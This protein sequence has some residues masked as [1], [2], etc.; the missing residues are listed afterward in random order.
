MK[1][2]LDWIGKAALVGAVAVIGFQVLRN[3]A[4]GGGSTSRPTE[5]TMV[6]VRVL[7][8]EGTL[9]EPVTMPAI[10][11]TEADWKELLTP[12]QFRIVRSAGTERPFCGGLLKNHEDGMY[13]CVACGL[14]LFKSDSKFESGTGWPSFFQPVAKENIEEKRDVSYGMVRVETNCQRC[15]AHLGH[16]FEDGPRP[17]GLRYCMNSESLKFVK[18]ADLKSAGEKLPTAVP[19]TQPAK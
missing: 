4:F 11:K 5:N 13:L 10:R 3:V 16:V 17:T 18:T 9:S 6:T 19:S 12:E 8:P 15:G 2:Q 14:P 1:S 7:T